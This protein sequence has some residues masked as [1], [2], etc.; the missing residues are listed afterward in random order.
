M[1][2]PRESPP[3]S[4]EEF[5]KYVKKEKQKVTWEMQKPTV[6]KPRNFAKDQIRQDAEAKATSRFIREAFK[7]GTCGLPRDGL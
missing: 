1:G 3:V 2:R 4:H 7:A 5:V 6:V